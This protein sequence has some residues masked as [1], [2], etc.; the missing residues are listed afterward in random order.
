MTPA[1]VFRAAAAAVETVGVF[2]SA[3]AAMSAA[4]VPLAVEAA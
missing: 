1:E 2:R 3:G 4:D